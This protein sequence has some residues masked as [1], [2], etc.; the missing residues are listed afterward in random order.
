MNCTKHAE[1]VYVKRIKI[2]KIKR[3]LEYILDLFSIGFVKEPRDNEIY[4]V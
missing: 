1:I 2:K 4:A 3:V